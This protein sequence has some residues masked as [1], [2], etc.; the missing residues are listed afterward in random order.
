[1]EDNITFEI[2][3]TPDQ[4]EE[5]K[6]MLR[7]VANELIARNM[8]L[9]NEEDLAD[10]ALFS[11]GQA[12]ICRVG[13]KAA[14]TFI[15]CDEDSLFWPHITDGKSLFVHNQWATALTAWGFHI[16]CWNLPGRRH[17]GGTRTIC[18]WTAAANG[19]NCV[20][21]MKAMALLL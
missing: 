1:M 11:D 7:Q 4:K 19:S 13:G 15:L 5:F 21:F 18:A 3:K 2:V 14:G 12:Y 10:E 6:D 16:R 17:S 9:W 8:P 20:R